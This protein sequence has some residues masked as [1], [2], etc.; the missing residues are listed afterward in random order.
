MDKVSLAA[1]HIYKTK[2]TESRG[3]IGELI[4][5]IACVQEFGASPVLLKLALKTSSNDTVKGYDGVHYV[6]RGCLGPLKL[7]QYLLTNGVA[8]NGTET[9]FG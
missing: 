3:E 7:C 4:L 5:H 8:K 6:A 9:V 2:K 1:R